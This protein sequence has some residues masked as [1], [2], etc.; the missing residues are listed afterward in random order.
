MAEIPAARFSTLPLALIAQAI[1][2]LSRHDLESL[3]ERLIDRLD[4]I[5]G[6][7]DLEPDDDCCEAGDD[8]C[9][10]II[11][12]GQT[13]WGSEREPI[14]ATRHAREPKANARTYGASPCRHY[15]EEN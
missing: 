15:S 2:K 4:E 8:G 9:G 5:D 3:T 1:P 11:R 12:N 10:P 14:G 7:P 13:H 6:D